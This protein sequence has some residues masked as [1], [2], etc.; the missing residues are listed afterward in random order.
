MFNSPETSSLTAA[1]T[2][3]ARKWRGKLF[4]REKEIKQSTRDEQIDDFLASSRPPVRQP[5]QPLQTQTLPAARLPPKI[6]VSVSQRWANAAHSPVD[7]SAGVSRN[8]SNQHRNYNSNNSSNNGNAAVAGPGGLKKRRRRCEGLRVKFC[9]RPPAIMGEGGEEAEDP[10]MEISLYRARSN[11]SASQFTDGADGGSSSDCSDSNARYHLD[12]REPTLPSFAVS[13]PDGEMKKS[14]SPNKER[15]LQPSPDLRNAQNS[16][17][18]L[19]IS[20]QPRGSRLSWRDT[21]EENSFAQRIRAKM[22]DEEGLA[23]QKARE[24]AAEQDQQSQQSRQPQQPQQ[25]Q[26]Q[27]SPE[28]V[29]SRDYPRDRSDSNNN[30]D[31]GRDYD[32]EYR[33]RDHGR[34]ARDEQH[35]RDA[36]RGSPQEPAQ[37][38][39]TGLSFWG[40]VM[41]ALPEENKKQQQQQQQQRQ[42]PDGYSPPRPNPPTIAAPP[43]SNP[44]LTKVT[45][46][47]SSSPPPYVRTESRQA[48]YNDSPQQQQS[49]RLQ[50]DKPAYMAHHPKT[51]SGSSGKLKN[52][53]NMVGDAALAEFSAYVERYITLFS[54]AAESVKPIMETSLSEW[55]RAS[56]WWFI[57]GRA[58]LEAF[59]RSRPSPNAGN[60]RQSPV[61][62]QC[63][64]AIINLAKAWWIND[65]L[66]PQHPELGQFGRMKPDAMISMVQSMGNDTLASLLS[67]HQAIISHLRA[68][69]MSMQ[70]NNIIPSSSAAGQLPTL[71]QNIDSSIWIRYPFFAPGISSVLSGSGSKSMLIDYSTKKPDIAETMPISDTNRHFCYGRMFVEVCLGSS[72]DDTEQYAIPCMLSITRDR[73]DW[74]V[75][76]TLT[77]QN[78]L[79]NL[80]IQSDKKQGPT[81]ADIDWQVRLQSLTLRLPR[82]FELDIK[83]QDADFKMLWKIVEYTRK[84]Q[85]DMQPAAGERLVFADILNDFQYTESSPNKTFPS[86][87]TQRCRIQLFEKTTKITEGTGTREFHRGFRFFAVTSPKVKTLSSVTHTL[88]NGSPIVFGYLRG[89]DGAPA[90]MLKHFENGDEHSMLLTFQDTEL[91][92]SLHSLLIGITTKESESKS[93]D[94]ALQSFTMIQGADPL[95]NSS[96][97]LNSRKTFLKFDKGNAAVINARPDHKHGVPNTVL[98]ESLRVFISSSWGS[99]TDRINIGPGDLKISLDINVPT[100]LS[101]MRPPQDDLSVAVAENMVPKEIPAQMKELLTV[102]KKKPIIRKYNFATLQDLHLFQQGITGFKV[103]FDGYASMFAI[104][105]RRMVVPIYKKWEASGARLQIIQQEKN[106]QLVVFLA[107]FSHGRSMNFVLKSTDNFESFNRSGKFGIKIVDAKFALPKNSEDESADFVCLDMPEY[108]GEHDDITIGFDS[109]NDRYSFQSAVPGSVKEPSRMGSLRK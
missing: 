29:S 36:D 109:E 59:M 39:K 73:S 102:S 79:V 83:F 13:G 2:K 25:H 96:N 101:V 23:L 9:D 87:P 26:H 95:G 100:T 45:K 6:D 19:S 69:S 3:V 27:H 75:I 34:R 65:Q 77:S 37:T 16:D 64:Q 58:E 40:S 60:G 82:G 53:A 28:Q 30:K 90:M 33:E 84:V 80:T 4:S 56:V 38:G 8:N 12:N 76:A 92:A 1:E 66:V 70:R 74:N 67:I 98:S 63:Q 85:A 50:P 43:P 15:Q 5:Q 47:P 42:G 104:A 22:R 97:T 86:E 88:G 14:G 71:S 20:Q 51:S 78:E 11:S 105:R 44:I 106:V 17:F 91:R 48:A 46:P 62:E 94:I 72:D 24:L 61:T 41:A 35:E 68:L 89:D 32:R 18:L 21:S 108:P 81:W 49:N 93:P 57:K 54:R 55:V 99:V 103:L 10:T 107:G 7:A 31:H 52:M